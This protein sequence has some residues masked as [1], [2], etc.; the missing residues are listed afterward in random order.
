MAGLFDIGSSGIQAYRK[1]LS[2]TGQNIANLNTEGYRR[3]EASMEEISA[4]QGNILSVSDQAGLGVRVSDISRAFDSFI[5]GRARDTASDFARADSYK[6]ALD[7]LETVLLP[8]DY[9]LTF[10]INEFFD[11]ISSIARAPGDTAGRVVALEQGRSLASAFQSLARSLQSFQTAIES[12]VRNNV[13]ALNTELS[14]LADI[15]AQLISAGGSGKASNALL[16]QRDKSISAIADYVGLSADYNVR[17]DARLTLGATGSGPILVESK[18]AGQLSV[19]VSDG[20][21]N[22]YA[23]MGGAQTQTQQL[24]S[25]GLAGLIAAYEAVSQTTRDLD[26]LARKVSRDLNSVHQGGI[27]LDGD[28]GKDLYSLDSYTLTPSATNLGA[29]T[30][31]VS[32]VGELP[33]ADIEL[34]I[35][36]DKSRALWSGAQ[37][38]GTVV[39]TGKNGFVYQGLDVSISG[40]AAD[41]DTLFF[42]VSRGKAENMAF[43][44]TRPEEFAAAG[45]L[46][47]S[48]GL[49]NQGSATLTAQA[50]TPYVASGF[51]SL[52]VSLPND[53]GVA[54]ATR[55]RSD[56]FAGVIPAS[57]R[58]LELFSLKTQDNVT[59]SLSDEQQTSLTE[60]T[61]T[62][63]G[64]EHSFETTAFKERIV[65]EADIDMANLA[66]MLNAGTITTGAGLSL[67]D[68]GVFA[69]GESGLLSLASAQASL[70]A[71]SLQADAKIT[72]SVSLGNDTGSQIQVFTRE[73]RQIAGTPLSD[74]DVMQY[75]T[76]ANGFLETAEYRADYLNG[77]A[78]GGLQNMSVS[79][80]TPV[81]TQSLRFSGE[82]FVPPVVTDSVMPLS[83]QTPAQTLFLSVS[84]DAAAEIEIPQGVMAD[85]IASEI[86]ALRGDLGVTAT[87]QTRVELS[88]IPDGIV[89]FSLTGDNTQAIDIEGYVSDGDVSDL[90]VLINAQTHET[91]VTAYVSSSRDKFVLLNN[92]G[93]DIVLGNIS[94]SGEALKAMPVGKAGHPRLD[95]SVSLGDDAASFARFGGEVTLTASANFSLTGTGGTKSSL[96]DSFEGGLITRV[97]D[98]AG[99]WQELSFQT[100][101]GIDGN[102]ARPD[103]SLASAAALNFS[104]SLETDG[105]AARL[106]AVV[107]AK[108]FSEFSSGAV[109]T[110]MAAQ[111]RGMTPVPTLT[112]AG[113]SDSSTLPQT[114]ASITLSLGTQDYILTM[115][116]GEI[117]VS[118]PEAGRL[119]AGFNE[120]LELVV[121]AHRGMET[122]QMLSV[123]SSASEASMAAFGLSESARQEVMTGRAFAADKLSE[124]PVTLTLEIAN[125][126][127][128]VSVTEDSSGAVSVTSD[129]ALPS[130]TLADIVVGE[131]GSYQFQITR[132]G[133]DTLESFRIIASD[134]ARTL[135]LT[136]TPN[137]I[138]VTEAGL[139]LSTADSTAVDVT[140]TA[141]SL[142]SEHLSLENLP[143]E[144]L[145]VIL[146]GDGARRLSAQFEEADQ[147]VQTGLNRPLE[148]LVSDALSGRLEIIDTIS[149]H[150]IATRYVDETG[151][152]NV[153]GLDLL[154]NGD[155]ATGDSFTIAAN[156]RGAGD[157]RNISQILALQS[158]NK[159][160]GQGGF[161]TS[162]SALITDMGAKVKAG[163]IAAESAEAV[164]DAARELES[165]F[166]G[167]NLDT[168]AAR[169]LEQQQAYQALARVLSTAKE[170]LDTLMNSI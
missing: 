19:T 33:E 162:F 44:L 167:V 2:V 146:T 76:P 168:E 28:A 153:A 138:L 12:E 103:G 128:E 14:G 88:E 110:A 107:E 79:R 46:L 58:S 80:K 49:D 141:D 121:S 34:E 118:G 134:G 131:D 124:T 86:N 83:V 90:A 39:A 9:D 63:D 97:V 89:R 82:G 67:A 4:T 142:I 21:I 150:S 94:T 16:D 85:Y 20:Q 65:S 3:R 78:E 8:E 74:A 38:D 77:V 48:E 133:A 15:Q 35:V 53:D 147:P 91:G 127:F 50:F 57:V 108:D 154:L 113:F 148:V 95:T 114:G 66:Q 11:G 26:A 117:L 68:L 101:E 165:E 75:L 29:I 137:Q 112:G 129:V 13:E 69:A 37:A 158:L 102:E 104:V 156:T 159:Q 123:S 115:D 139:R 93:A 163:T 160:T 5:V 169:L 135:G 100:T 157:G 132:S 106:E 71:A 32:A 51:E 96:A 81:G 10:S 7:T 84:S 62:L 36:Y 105:S 25:G 151:R 99:S 116:D 119:S 56:G 23:G 92:T 6:G 18:A 61:L 55:L 24:T 31:Y 27:T 45:Q 126:Y 149:G 59:F 72:G 60:L 170:L 1:A 73:G 70:T 47:T 52:M 120:N 122:G 136:T 109:A 87:A 164:R 145:I 22:V 111:L 152:I 42:S 161:A 130:N 17:G 30:S 64:T 54:A 140:G 98:Q 40:Q 144:E 155:V 43:L 41:G 166:S 125:A 143:A